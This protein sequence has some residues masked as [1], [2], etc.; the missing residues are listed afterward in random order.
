M[1]LDLLND[2]LLDIKV[3]SIQ[4]VIPIGGGGSIPD[5]SI[6]NIKLVDKT[7]ENTKIK[8]GTIIS[9]LL[10]NDLTIN[11]NLTVNGPTFSLPNGDLSVGNNITATQTITGSIFS[12]SSEVNTPY[13]QTTQLHVNNGAG[14]YLTHGTGTLSGGAAQILTSAIAA[15]SIVLLT[16]TSDPAVDAGLLAVRYIVPSTSFDVYSSTGAD[17]GTFSWLIINPT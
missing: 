3:H 11:N 8:D 17:N 6:L 14:D 16:R 15:T 2:S 9:S 1:S 12:A 10:D 7:I 4:S 13:L 5:N